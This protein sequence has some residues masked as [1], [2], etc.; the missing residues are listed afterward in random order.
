M[1]SVRARALTNLAR[2]RLQMVFVIAGVLVMLFTAA[3][4]SSYRRYPS[5]YCQGIHCSGARCS[6]QLFASADASQSE[7][8]SRCEAQRCS[9]WQWRNP[10][11]KH[12][13]PLEP[14]CLTTN[15]SNAVHA[16]TYGYAAYVDTAKPPSPV[17]APTPTPSSARISN[18]A[19]RSETGSD[20]YRF[21]NVSLPIETRLD[22]LVARMTVSEKASQLQ[23][24]SSPPIDRLGI[25]FFC[26]GQNAIT[27]LDDAVFPI[28]PAMAATFNITNNVAAMAEAIAMNARVGFNQR[29]TNHSCAC[30]ALESQLCGYATDQWFLLL[31]RGRGF[32]AGYTCPGSIVTWGP[33]VNIDRDPRYVNQEDS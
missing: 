16:S 14:A 30:S 21:C 2:P 22:D 31:A 18:Y 27:G 20:H 1:L 28:A 17:P 26:W 25:P 15:E 13:S 5:S 4:T 10:S 23:A 8:E 9:C 32:T 33:T 11:D 12:P 19:C 6:G 29:T 3:E 7:C 24:R